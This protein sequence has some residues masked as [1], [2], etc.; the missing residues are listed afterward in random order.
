MKDFTAKFE[1]IS[2]LDPKMRGLLFER[3]FYEIFESHKILLEKS[4]KND[5]GSQ[6]IDGAVEINNRIFL[7]EIKWGERMGSHLD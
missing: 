7:V 5:D 2:Q 4:F 1:K 3:L 6:Q